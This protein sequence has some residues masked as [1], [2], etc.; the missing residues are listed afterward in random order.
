MG[1]G[2]T[3]AVG[4]GR[5]VMVEVVEVVDGGGGAARGEVRASALHEHGFWRSFLGQGGTVS[6]RARPQWGI[7]SHENS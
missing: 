3:V 5:R 1:V 6:I 2:K 7:L 4:D